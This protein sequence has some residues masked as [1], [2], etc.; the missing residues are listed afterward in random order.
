M[1]A[2]LAL[3]AAALAATAAGA[4]ETAQ[5]PPPDSVAARMKAL[6]VTLASADATAAQREAAREEL[7]GLLKSPAGQAKGRSRDEKPARAAIDPFPSVAA[8]TPTASPAPILSAP[9]SAGVA[10]LEVVDPPK[11]VVDPRTGSA[12]PQ[13]GRFAIDP[14]T[15]SVLHETPAGFIDPKTGRFLPR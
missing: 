12:A 5:W 10:T 4:L 14:R 1:R 11:L 6:Q 2:R 8:R 13:S 15:G 3:M 7:S 9:P